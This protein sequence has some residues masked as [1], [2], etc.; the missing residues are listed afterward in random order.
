MKEIVCV[1]VTM[2]TIIWGIVV[3]VKQISTKAKL[4][5]KKYMGKW[6]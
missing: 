2:F 1:S 3:E 4:L 6:R 5:R